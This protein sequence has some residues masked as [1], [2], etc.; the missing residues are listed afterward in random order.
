[1]WQ[2]ESEEGHQRDE[3]VAKGMMSDLHPNDLLIKT[4]FITIFVGGGIMPVVQ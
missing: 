2:G 3:R 1:V 4:V